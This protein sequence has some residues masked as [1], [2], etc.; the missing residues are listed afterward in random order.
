M[1]AYEPPDLRLAASRARHRAWQAWIEAERR[2]W[3]P[4]ATA[5]LYVEVVLSKIETTLAPRQAV[6]A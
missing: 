3:P 6:A 2:S 5:R 1:D 4:P